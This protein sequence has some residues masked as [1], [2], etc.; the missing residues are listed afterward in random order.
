MVTVFLLGAQLEDSSSQCKDVFVPMSRI[1][2]PSFSF[3]RK[4]EL[5][6]FLLGYCIHGNYCNNGAVMCE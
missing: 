6:I 4:K 5:S 1:N 3:A 2:S